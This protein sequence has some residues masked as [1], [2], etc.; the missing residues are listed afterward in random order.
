MM[1]FFRLIDNNDL[2]RVTL[3][4]DNTHFLKKSHAMNK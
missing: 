3:I 1:L 2:Q 4:F